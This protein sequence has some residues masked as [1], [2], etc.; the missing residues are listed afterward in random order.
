MAHDLPVEP[1]FG[2]LQVIMVI[3]VVGCQLLR[4]WPLDLLALQAVLSHERDQ[5]GPGAGCGAARHSRALW[6]SC[7]GLL[8]D[9]A[10]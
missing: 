8:I 3:M 7:L 6:K 10:S 2:R 9:L 5:G 1:I 4:A